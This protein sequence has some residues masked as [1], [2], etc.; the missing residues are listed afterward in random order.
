MKVRSFTGWL[1]AL[2]AAAPLLF[3]QPALIHRNLTLRRSGN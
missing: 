2:A 1:T 3:G